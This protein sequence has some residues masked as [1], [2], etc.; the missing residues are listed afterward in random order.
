MYS[1]LLAGVNVHLSIISLMSLNSL[2]CLQCFILFTS[3][4]VQ[5]VA[6]PAFLLFASA[7]GLGK[8]EMSVFCKQFCQD[9]TFSSQSNITSLDFDVTFYD[10]SCVTLLPSVAHNI[11]DD[12]VKLSL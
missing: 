3:R 8:C 12:L 7:N 10:E 1:P 2:L 5:I 11:I 4:G 9:C 6:N